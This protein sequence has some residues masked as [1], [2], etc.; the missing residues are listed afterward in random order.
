MPRKSFREGDWRID[1]MK[2][3]GKLRALAARR[4]FFLPA[5]YVNTTYEPHGNRKKES[6]QKGCEKSS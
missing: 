5:P 4:N 1:S 3:A 2:F 6:S